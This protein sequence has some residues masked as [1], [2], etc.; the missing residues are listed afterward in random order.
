MSDSS[1]PLTLFSPYIGEEEHVVPHVM[2][3]VDM[4]EEPSV[5]YL[6]VKICCRLASDKAHGVTV[7]SKVVPSFSKLAK[8]VNNDTSQNAEHEHHDNEIY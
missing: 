8:F 2:L 4:V 1:F 3:E 6:L 7:F 5:P